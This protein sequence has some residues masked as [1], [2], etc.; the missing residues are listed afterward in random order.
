MAL[1]DIFESSAFDMFSLTVAVNKLPYL[2]NRL[3]ELSIFES[4]P[5]TNRHAVVEEKLGKLSLLPSVP[6]GSQN[7]TTRSSERRKLRAFMVPHVPQWDEV[8]AEDLEG[9][10]AFGSEDQTEIFSQVL[11]DRLQSMKQNHEATWEYHRAGALHGVVLDNDG[12]TTIVNWFTE[13]GITQVTLAVDFT[14]AG[15]YALPNPTVDLK[16]ICGQ[17]QRT[18]QKQLG[19][20]PFKGIRALCGGRF[21]DAFTHHGTVRM[22]YER[23]Q[24]NQFARQLQIPGG[25]QPQGF[26]FGDIAWENY[27]GYVGTTNFFSA[28]EAIVYPEGTRDIF[29]DVPAPADFIETVNTRGQELYAKQRKMD[30]DK[31]IELHTQSNR[32][33]MCTRPGCL[34]K[35]TATGTGIPSD[36]DLIS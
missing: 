28:T 36:D 12:S 15:T 13:F 24:E 20:T 35:L 23:Y 5:S 9:K 1:L 7:Q 33:F 32:L 22:A 10:R 18:M 21:F 6:R 19:D 26:M 17:I 2:P 31:G 34:I 11:A 4:K 16:T 29:I 27:R 14:D 8:L 3:A 25:S 30:W